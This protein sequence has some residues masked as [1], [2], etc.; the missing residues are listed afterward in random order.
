MNEAVGSARQALDSVLRSKREEGAR[1]HLLYLEFHGAILSLQFHES[2]G[3]VGKARV[4]LEEARTVA[5]QPGAPERLFP[6]YIWDSHDLDAYGRLL[7]AQLA[8]L[9]QVF[10][11]AMDHYDG[12]MNASRQH[13]RRWRFRNVRARRQVGQVF[14]CIG[15]KCNGCDEC[16]CAAADLQTLSQDWFLGAAGRR[17]AALGSGLAQ[18]RPSN[19]DALDTVLAETEKLLPLGSHHHDPA[20]TLPGDEMVTG[21]PGYFTSLSAEVSQLRRL[22]FR[23]AFGREGTRGCSKGVSAGLER[24]SRLIPGDR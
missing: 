18:V 12:W 19:R 16:R 2:Q 15:R 14:S 21:L 17:L 3:E 1:K 23:Q 9:K 20:A 24:G 11:S 8:Y 10:K 7:D 5:L 4:A 6:G 13:S 22:G